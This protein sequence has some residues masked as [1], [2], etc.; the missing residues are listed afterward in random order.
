MAGFAPDLILYQAGVDPHGGDKLGRLAL[1]D[2]GLAARDR[3]VMRAAR[4]AGVPLASTMGG[5]YGA[6]RLAVARRHAAAI[7]TLADEAGGGEA[8]GDGAAGTD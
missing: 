8:A 2:A 3:Y 7:L 4:R 6:D 5:G 1:T